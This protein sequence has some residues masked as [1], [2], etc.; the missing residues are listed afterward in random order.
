MQA[1][2]LTPQWS[3][4]RLMRTVWSTDPLASRL[5]SQFHP[6][7]YTWSDQ[8][9]QFALLDVPPLQQARAQPAS[10]R[11]AAQSAGCCRAC[12]APPPPCGG[13]P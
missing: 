9:Q 11:W 3:S 2:G 13:A 8:E 10:S 7:V 4:T 1:S 5:P 6:S 12:P